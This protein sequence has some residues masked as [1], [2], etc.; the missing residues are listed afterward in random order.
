MNVGATDLISSRTG[1]EH[2]DD[3]SLSAVLA[4]ARV[5]QGIIRRVHDDQARLML[6]RRSA[7]DI[8][9]YR[10]SKFKTSQHKQTQAG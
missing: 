8:A 10:T 7:E 1:P 4:G 9:V 2:V 6:A 3:F 5:T